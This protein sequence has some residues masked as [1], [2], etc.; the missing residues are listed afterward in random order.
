[1]GI[2][3]KKSARRKTQP[4]QDELLAEGHL[5]EAEDNMENDKE[6][7]RIAV[8]SS[9]SLSSSAVM[10]ASKQPV[11]LSEAVLAAMKE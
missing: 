11:K 9:S 5:V 4:T 2:L 10:K 3:M 1:M 7:S 6:D 8:Q